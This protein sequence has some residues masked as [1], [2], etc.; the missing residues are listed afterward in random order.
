MP[1]CFRLKYFFL[2]MSNTTVSLNLMSGR[3]A[4]VCNHFKY[5]CVVAQLKNFSPDQPFVA[6]CTNAFEKQVASVGVG[7][8]SGHLR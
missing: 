1:E 8:G 6:T 5:H 7:A 4:S 3:I 2:D